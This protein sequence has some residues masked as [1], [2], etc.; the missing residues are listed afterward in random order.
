MS[1]VEHV[2]DW[3]ITLTPVGPDHGEGGGTLEILST[4][5]EGAVEA[6][7]FWAEMIRT[8]GHVPDGLDWRNHAGC[9][10]VA[11]AGRHAYRV[12]CDTF[13][14]ETQT[15]TSSG[16]GWLRAEEAF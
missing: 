1:A 11:R 13:E 5:E 15:G 4:D 10:V 9:A 14:R 6:L 16:A 2:R 3:R 8:T 12:R 7:V